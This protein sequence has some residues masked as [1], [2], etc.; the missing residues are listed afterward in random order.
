[1]PVSSNSSTKKL[2]GWLGIYGISPVKGWPIISWLPS[3][4]FEVSGPNP[5]T[6]FFLNSLKD[7]FAISW[8]VIGRNSSSASIT[9]TFAPNLDQTLP[10]SRPIMPAPIIPNFLG[11]SLKD[12]APVLSTIFLLNFADWI[13]IGIEPVAMMIFLASICVIDP[14][15]L[16]TSTRTSDKT[17]PLPTIVG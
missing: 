17:L 12:S 10:N 2:C 9:V 7:S 1:M 15:G 13:S 5:K 16:V 14:S 3:I 8:S 6:A 11:T 4:K